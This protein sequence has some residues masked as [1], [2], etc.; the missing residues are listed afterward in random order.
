MSFVVIQAG[1]CLEGENLC[2][3]GTWNPLGTVWS[4]KHMQHKR[5]TASRSRTTDKRLRAVTRTFPT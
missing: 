3:K 4:I 5:K 2:S 1:D